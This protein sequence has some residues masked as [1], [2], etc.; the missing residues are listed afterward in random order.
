MSWRRRHRRR[1]WV[2]A[3]ALALVLP[4]SASAG[5]PFALDSGGQNPHVAVGEDGTGHF[6]WDSAGVDSAVGYCQVPRGGTACTRARRWT[7]LEG[8]GIS[9]GRA[10]SSTPT[11]GSSSSPSRGATGSRSSRG[12]RRHLLGA[13]GDQPAAAPAP[14]SAFGPSW[15]RARTRSRISLGGKF[16]AAP[17]DGP[18]TSTAHARSARCSTA[19]S[20]S[21]IR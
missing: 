12:R 15:V 10:C 18:P 3:V 2:L 20:P 16:K 5:Q 19:A 13:D 8:P 17:L 7:G 14:S 11:G 1:A 4:V 6:V 21:S 9:R